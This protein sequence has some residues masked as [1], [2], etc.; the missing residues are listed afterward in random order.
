[1]HISRH[2][3]AAFVHLCARQLPL[4]WIV[5]LV[6]IFEGSLFTITAQIHFGFQN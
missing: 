3:M 2:E 5:I 4:V 6:N 1:M